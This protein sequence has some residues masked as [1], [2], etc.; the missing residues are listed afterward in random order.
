MNRRNWLAIKLFLL[1]VSL[2]CIGII[3]INYAE[4]T[5][6]MIIGG[7]EKL[8]SNI[9]KIIVESVNLPVNIYEEDVEKVTIKDNSKVYGLSTGKPNTID[10]EDGV[11][12]VKQEKNYSFLFFVTGE[13]I[14]EVPK[15]S[16]LE[17]DINS[18]SG[19]I[20]HTALSKD[21]LRAKSISG[22]VRIH[23]GSER[24][25]IE[26]ISGSVRIHAPFQEVSASSVS[27]SIHIVANQDTK[28][29][30]TSTISGST[31]IQLE[32]V[33]GYNMEYSTTSGSIKDVYEGLVYSK[34]GSTTLRD[35]YLKINSS[36]VSGS[37]KLED[38]NN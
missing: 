38:W 11:L 12:S 31:S 25:T 9:E 28:Q 15:G 26:T 36:S 5:D 2:F 6:Q 32:N 19:K 30:L 13:I 16:F 1:T 14:I 37:I 24:V 34:K 29:I 27:G 22:A 35:S 7:E 18:I 33:S 21:T 17:Y 20:N 10:E 23:R 3:A 8:F 4:F